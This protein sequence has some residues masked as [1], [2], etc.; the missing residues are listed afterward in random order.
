[1]NKTSRIL[2]IG[3]ITGV[4]ILLMSLSLVKTGDRAVIYKADSQLKEHVYREAKGK[5]VEQIIN[6]SLRQT[7]S[8]LQFSRHNDINNGQANCVGYAQ[9]CAAICNQALA[10]NGIK[11]KAKP[12]VGYIESN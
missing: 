12:V 2:I 3:S 6:Y 7:A 11:G 10:A 1:M 9:L 4:C 5:S 8:Y